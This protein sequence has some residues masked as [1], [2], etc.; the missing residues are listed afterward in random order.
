MGLLYGGVRA[1][2]RRDAAREVLEQ[3]GLGNRLRH[4][5]NQLSGGERQ[6]LAI[7]RAIVGRPA[8][9]LADEPT[10]NLDS[11]RSM[12]IVALLRAL[13]DRGTTVVIITHDD[14]VAAETSRQVRI[15]DGRIEADDRV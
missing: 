12:E 13:N 4:R 1:R 5:P 3:V 11:K 14:A 7:A 9:V 2:E 10:G 8:L 6:R 15:A